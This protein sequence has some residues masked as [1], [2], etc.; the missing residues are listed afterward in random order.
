[1][2]AMA[3]DDDGAVDAVAAEEGEAAPQSFRELTESCR[4]SFLVMVRDD[5][6]AVEAVAAQVV[7]QSYGCVMGEAESNSEP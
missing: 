2:A 6:E 3:R 4:L 1:M 5:D 7:A